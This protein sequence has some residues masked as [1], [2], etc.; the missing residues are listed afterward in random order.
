MASLNLEKIAA[1]SDKIVYRLAKESK[2]SEIADRI[3]PENYMSFE[4][5][6]KEDDVC[7]TYGP[8]I[9]Y[10]PDTD[11]N[12]NDDSGPSLKK[13]DL[14]GIHFEKCALKYIEC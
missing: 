1:S 9:D 8:H 12:T 13:Q 6:G 3:G 11:L 10:D 7:I 4:F 2:S 14:D 5:P